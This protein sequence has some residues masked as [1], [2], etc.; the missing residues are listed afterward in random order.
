MH[1]RLKGPHPDDLR[2]AQGS[3]P[4]ALEHRW[5]EHAGRYLIGVRGLDPKAEPAYELGVELVPP[6]PQGNDGLEPNDTPEQARDLSKGKQ[7]NLRVCPSDTDWYAVTL[8]EGEKLA[9]TLRYPPGRGELRAELVST[10]GESLALGLGKD[11]QASVVLPEGLAPARI[12]LKVVGEAEGTDNRYELELSDAPP[13]QQEQPKDQQ[14][15][16]K[17]QQEQPKDQQEQPKDQQEQPEDEQPA[18]TPE[19]Q[20]MDQAL[21]ALEREDQNVQLEKLLRALPP[22]RVERDW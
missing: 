21:D 14:D 6:C 13:D 5:V 4:L 8:A 2:E 19:R 3:E 7:Q 11:G 16:P 10:E 12:L 22:Q 17:D 20:A 15:Q 9:A 1:L 18:P